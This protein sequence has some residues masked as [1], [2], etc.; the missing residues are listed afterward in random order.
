MP[1]D[2]I[3]LRLRVVLGHELTPLLDEEEARGLITRQ[4]RRAVLDS[5][6]IARGELR[7]AG[8]DAY[9]VAEV[10]TVIDTRDV[11]R[12][13]ERARI[14]AHVSGMPA[15]A[16][17]GG[18]LITPDADREARVLGVRRVTDGHSEEEA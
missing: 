15:V 7:D 11:Y 12:A 2:D 9:L 18:E 6:V 14:L 17:V 10:S 8:A 4:Q 13:V 1:I 5:D 3:L 16:V